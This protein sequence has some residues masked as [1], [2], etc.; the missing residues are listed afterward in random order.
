[1]LSNGLEYLPTDRHNRIQARSG[2]LKDNADRSTP[3]P[4]KRF[5]RQLVDGGFFNHQFPVEP[6]AETLWYNPDYR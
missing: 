3:N 5:L 6:N 2:F 4:A 1:M